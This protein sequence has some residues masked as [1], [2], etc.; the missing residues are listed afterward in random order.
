MPNQF[1]PVPGWFSWENQ[2]GGVAAFDLDGSGRPDLIVFQ[3]DNPPGQNSGFYKVGRDLDAQGVPA[4][5]GDWIP[6]PGWFSRENAGGDITAADLDGSGRPDLIVFMIDNPPGQNSGF[7]KIGRGLDGA[8]QVTGGWSDWIAIPGWFSFEN[9]DGGIATFDISGSGRPDLVVFMIDNGAGLNQGLYKIGWNLDAQGQVTGGW[10]DWLRVETWSSWENQGAGL[11]ITD[12]DGNGRPELIVFQI[13]NPP[14]PNTGF[15]QIGWNVDTSGIV[16]EG[17]GPWAPVGDW[18]TEEDAGGGVALADLN[19]DGKPELIVFHIAALPG[20]NQG[21][22]AAVDLSLDTSTAAEIGLWRVLPYTSDVLP[23]HAALLPGGEVFFFAGSGNST[24]RFNSPAYAQDQIATGVVWNQSRGNVFEPIANLVVPGTSRP[25][26]LFC[27]NEAFLADGRLL[28]VGGTQVYDPFHG[29]PEAQTLDP[30]TRAWTP[31]PPMSVGRW[32]PAIVTLGDGRVLV[33]SGLD[34]AGQTTD[35]LE[36]Y[37]EGR[38]FQPTGRLAL[39]LYG[40]LVLLRDGRI[41]YTGGQMDTAAPSAPC[42]F[43]AAATAVQPVGGLSAVALRNQSASVLLPPAQDQRVLLMGGGPDDENEA[44]ANADIV[45]FTQA[46]PAYTPATPMNFDRMHLNA[47][48]LPDRTVLVSGG[49]G[50]REEAILARRH[51]EVYDPQT[52]AWTT[53]AEATIP[54]MYHSIALLLPDGRVVAAGSNPARGTRDKW[55]E[56]VPVMPDPNEELRLEIFSPPYLFRGERPTITQTPT[57]W[58]YGQTISVQTPDVA[59]IQGISLIRAGCTTHSYNTGQRLVDVPIT[60]REGTTLV[61]QVP[62]EPNVAPPGWYMLFLV[63]IQG[64]PSVASWV[65]LT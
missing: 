21:L 37:R 52:N 47:V 38:G 22:A 26:D 30:Q 2:G 3:I 16:T 64:V 10:T 59:T 57:Q 35:L 56:P 12:L 62:A 44:T 4:A 20:V 53:L 36:V 61:G 14:G 29:R 50:K 18:A 25:V 17:Y 55:K 11:A 9:Q 54:R 41:F 40:H 58:A 1:S 65:Q 8:G 33:A 34:D 49:A 42:V 7:Y 5:W 32:Y 51:A 28:V 6:I 15:Y 60:G 46:A 39:P 48:L 63:N 24:V 43:D 31:V 19:G 23:V 13:D 27:G 45:D